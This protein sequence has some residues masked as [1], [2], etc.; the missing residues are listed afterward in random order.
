MLVI[1][2]LQNVV[3]QVAFQAG[4]TESGYKPG[5]LQ[6]SPEFRCFCCASCHRSLLP[7]LA[8]LFQGVLASFQLAL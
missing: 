2:G 3:N 7:S 8:R 1:Q 4:G 5:S 6:Q